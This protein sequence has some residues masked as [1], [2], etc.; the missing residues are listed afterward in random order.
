[1]NQ[2]LLIEQMF[3]MLVSGDRAM[4]RRVSETAFDNGISAQQMTL[5]IYWPLLEN[6][7]TMYRQDQITQLAQQYA[8]RTLSSLIAQAQPHYEVKESRDRSICMFCGN[9]ELEDL[10]GRLVADILESEGYNVRFGGGNINYDDIL[11]EIHGRQPEV[12]LLFASGPQDAPMIRQLIDHIRSINAYPNM[13]IV[14]GGGIFNRAPGLA[15][16]IGADLWATDPTDLLNQLENNEHV[17]AD[18]SERTV[19]RTRNEKVVAA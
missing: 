9:S 1:M 17:R 16:E 19:G 11:A 6:V 10:S 12:L 8:T 5:D 2:E 18:L 7:Y 15:E 3:Q 4:A 13:Q 14:V